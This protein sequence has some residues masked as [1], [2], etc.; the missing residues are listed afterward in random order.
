MPLAAQVSNQLSNTDCLPSWDKS[1]KFNAGV[2]T[3]AS[4]S[5]TLII[6]FFDNCLHL[7]CKLS[8]SML[9]YQVPILLKFS[10][11]VDIW[12]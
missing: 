11:E 4:A 5:F 8:E 1:L 3:K 6:D 9:D 12:G 7:L 10:M 2:N